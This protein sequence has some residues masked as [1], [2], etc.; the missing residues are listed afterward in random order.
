MPLFTLAYIEGV[1]GRTYGRTY[2][3]FLGSMGYHIFLAMVLRARSPAINYGN[4]MVFARGEC[5]ASLSLCVKYI[6]VFAFDAFFFHCIYQ[7]GKRKGI[8]FNSFFGTA[9]MTNLTVSHVLFYISAG[10]YSNEDYYISFVYKMGFLEKNT[11]YH[12]HFRKTS[13]K[14]ILKEPK[15]T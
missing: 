3:A 12:E 1:D 6:Y 4:C 10:I 14:N 2:A 11:S 8:S 9:K 15:L 7:N 5:L 13:Q